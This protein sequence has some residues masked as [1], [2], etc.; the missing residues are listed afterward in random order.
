VQK[1]A[2]KFLLQT[3]KGELAITKRE[4]KHGVATAEHQLAPCRSALQ[5]Y[6]VPQGAAHALKVE[7]EIQAADI[8]LHPFLKLWIAQD[9]RTDRLPIGPKLRAALQT[10]VSQAT[11]ALQVST[12]ADISTW[13]AAGFVPSSEPSGTRLITV[14][15]NTPPANTEGALYRMLSARQRR[16]INPI[17]K[18]ADVYSD[19][20]GAVVDSDLAAWLPQL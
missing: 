2:Y 8:A 12:C 17:K 14:Y 19:A 15:V 7:L 16:T 10:E 9:R 13:Q 1:T 3:F 18:A 11:A 5:G 6:S 20:L 4:A